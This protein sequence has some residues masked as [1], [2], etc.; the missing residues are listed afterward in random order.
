MKCLLME[1]FVFIDQVSKKM[2]LLFIAIKQK[3]HNLVNNKL[4]WLCA[5]LSHSVVSDSLQPHGL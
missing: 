3:I 4:I 2:I 5:V 1:E